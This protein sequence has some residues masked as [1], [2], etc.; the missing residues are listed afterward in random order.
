[1]KKRILAFVLVVL[2][3]VTVFAGCS[4][5]LYGY[6]NYEQYIRL[7]QI[8]G[9][10]IN[11]SDINDGI[12]NAFTGLYDVTNDKLTETTYN[13]DTEGVGDIYIKTGD[14]VNI[15]YV[16]KKDGVAF[17]GGTATGYDLTIG[18]NAFIDGFEDGL[19]GYKVGDKP[20]LNLTFPEN[21]GNA[22]LKGA[23]VVFEVTINSVKRV[24]YPEYNDANIKEKT[25]Y[26]TVAEFEE[27]T[28]KTVMNN[29]IW[30]ELYSSSKIVSYPKKE[31]KIK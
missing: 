28:K 19:I 7:G 25:D 4:A 27:A 8:D 5:K 9:I 2:T 18:S 13:K 12:R 11:Q 26:E 21:Y 22:E 14:V 17:S 15:D 29:L 10:K 6:D 23:A 3:V 24:A 30:Q 1:M 20:S 16:G 31:L